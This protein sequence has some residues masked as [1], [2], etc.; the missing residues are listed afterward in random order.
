MLAERS[1]TTTHRKSMLLELWGDDNFFNA[2]NMDVYISK[3]RRY[4]QYDTSV[5][6]INVRGQGYKLVF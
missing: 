6:L 5:Q 1:N 2:R 4:F 3:L